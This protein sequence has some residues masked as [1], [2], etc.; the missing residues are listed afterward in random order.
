MND[1][2]IAVLKHAQIEAGK[3][4]EIIGGRFHERS[5]ISCQKGGKIYIGYQ[6]TKKSDIFEIQGDAVVKY[7]PH[8]SENK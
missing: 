5:F 3:T 8:L 1:N 2:K 7:E 6:R 4:Y